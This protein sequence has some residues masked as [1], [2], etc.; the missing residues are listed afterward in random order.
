MIE[1]RH[2]HCSARISSRG[3][4]LQ[5]LRRRDEE[6]LWQADPAVWGQHAPWLFPFVGRLRA[7]GFT[8]GGKHYRMP[9]HGFAS[10][11]DFRVVRLQVDSVWLEAADDA[12]TREV[13]PFA[14][15][16]R[17]GY[18]LHDD[19]LAIAVEVWNRGEETLPF[20]LGAHPGFALPGPLSHW[21]LQFDQAEADEVWRLTPGP[22]A[23]LAATAEAFTWSAPGRLDL[24]PDTFARDAL[25]VK[26]PRSR[27]VALL[28]H[29]RQHLAVECVGVDGMAHL[30]LWARPSAS[31][32]CIEPWWGHDDDAHAPAALLDK[33]Q[34]QH[35]PPD[36]T[37]A[38]ALFIRL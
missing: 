17:I 22:D 18:M 28:R 12:F 6:L 36:E 23:L 19:G 1:L 27:R 21:A 38:R 35:L 3:A 32:V 11:L 25:I 33:P 20:A 14:F 4:E 34:V 26:R 9:I 10:G 24:R 15:R 13:Y 29:G 31:Y 16:L 7:G 30:G 5:S 2:G 8:H 37:W